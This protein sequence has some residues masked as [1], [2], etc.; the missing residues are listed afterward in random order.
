MPDGLDARG[1][2]PIAECG[3][4]G[5]RQQRLA[6]GGD[7]HHARRD[8][9]RDPFDLERLGA[10]RDVGGVVRAQAHRPDVQAHARAQPRV[11]RRQRAVVVERVAERVRGA[12]E[13]QQKA[14][15]LV[16]LAP[17]PGAQPLARGTVVRGPQRA[18]RGVAERLGQPRA[19]DEIGQEEG[20]F[21]HGA[22][23]AA[24]CTRPHEATRGAACG[25]ARQGST[26][27][28]R[29]GILATLTFTEAR[30]CELR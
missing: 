27:A 14:V 3:P 17:A 11:D 25:R 20:A 8:R 23:G 22:R 21:A 1:H 24:S 28:W 19:V 18:R 4:R 7:R 16:D 9:L 15:A 6:G 30:P 29:S 13:E 10:A 5:R 12:V 26:P 2:R